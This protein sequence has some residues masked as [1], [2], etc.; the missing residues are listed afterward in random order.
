MK[1]VHDI[2]R[3][4]LADVPGQLRRLADE[5]EHRHIRT[6]AVVIDFA[7]ENTIDIPTFGRDADQLRTIGLLQLANAY[8]TDSI[9][10]WGRQHSGRD[11][12]PA[13]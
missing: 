10:E 3:F 13:A 1:V 8:L 12:D 2:T 5:L 11:P 6:C 7:D 4:N 9:I